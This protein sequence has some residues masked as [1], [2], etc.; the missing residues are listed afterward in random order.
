MNFIIV[1][2]GALGTIAGA[3]LLNGGHAVRIVARGERAAFVRAHGLR[4]S[5][6]CQMQQTCEVLER[7]PSLSEHDVVIYAVKTYHMEAALGSAGETRPR[8]VF[9]FANGVLKNEQLAQTFGAERVIGCM[10]NFS[11]ELTSEGDA[12]FTR[13]V[14]IH[15]G[16]AKLDCGELVDCFNQCGLVASQSDTIETVEWSKFVGWVALF[17]LS[18][19]SR[20]V[21]G[22]FLSNA[23]LARVAVSIVREAAAVADARGID[24]IDQSPMPVSSIARAPVEQAVGIVMDTGAGFL[25][26]APAHR[27]S[28]LQDFEAGRQLE[29]HE[30]LGFI[31]AEADR[32]GLNADT[33]RNCYRIIAGLNELPR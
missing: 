15:L 24:L 6:L 30:T 21:T 5:G 1:G 19:L 31:V 32:L 29:V 2:A 16:A 14:C 27:M 20:A 8:A 9:S 33:C 3:H 7:L 10:A 12:T 28:S 13:N 4:V 25:K 22:R 18:V 11:G 17:S 23:R 26:D